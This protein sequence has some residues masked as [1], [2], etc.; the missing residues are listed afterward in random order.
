MSILT[1][2]IAVDMAIITT[3]CCIVLYP[4]LVIEVKV[5]L[6]L[7]TTGCLKY[8]ND[9]GI[10]CLEEIDPIGDEIFGA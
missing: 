7:G 8:L 4:T 2:F 10:T 3:Q 1:S 6:N 9:Y 5:S